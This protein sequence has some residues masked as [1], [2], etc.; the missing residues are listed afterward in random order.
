MAT[1]RQSWMNTA[2]AKI[3]V[4]ETS[5]EGN[6]E[7]IMKWAK[8]LGLKKS[9]YPSDATPWCGLF[10]AWVMAQNGVE[11]VD[12]PLWA[13]NW[14]KFGTKLSEPAFGAIMVFKRNGGGHVGFYVSEDANNYHILGGNQSD[15]VNITK[16]AKN[17]CIGYR[18]PPDMEKFLVKGRIKKAM[19]GSISTNEA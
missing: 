4:E 16:V 19:S 18:W 14:N 13:Q 12:E 6:T 7:E 11:P 2:N 3:G 10:V 17:R 15:S 5:G 8:M 9:D 1:F